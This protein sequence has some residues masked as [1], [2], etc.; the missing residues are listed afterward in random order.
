MQ[1]DNFLKLV[2]SGKKALSAKGDSDLPAFQAI[3]R[4]A[5]DAFSSGYITDFKLHFNYET[6]ERYVD[7]IFVGEITNSGRKL[8]L[9]D[10]Q[11][12]ID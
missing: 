7:S 8:L 5:K 9:S 3:V 10:S 1:L 12:K 6:R 2:A 4:T 11:H